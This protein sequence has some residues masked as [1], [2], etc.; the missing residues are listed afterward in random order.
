[1]SQLTEK[2]SIFAQVMELVEILSLQEQETLIEV[3]RKW[4]D[5][6]RREEI[7]LSIAE[8]HEEYKAG[9]AKPMTVDELMAEITA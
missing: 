4:V 6:K 7:A 5:M 1:M 3:T 2:T 8:A 9:K